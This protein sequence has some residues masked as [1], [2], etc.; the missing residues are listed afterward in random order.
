MPIAVATLAITWTRVPETRAPGETRLDL[1]GATLAT[2]GLGGVVFGLL[3]APRL[4]FTHP[5]IIAALGGGTAA[6]GTFLWVEQHTARPMLPLDVFRSRTFSGA[7]L[8]TLLLYAALSGILFFLPF[9][10][11]QVHGYTP[12]EAG[13]ALLPLIALL[14]LLS[15]WAGRLIDRYGPRPPLVAGP[16]VAGLGFVLLA[17]PGTSGAYWTTFFP[18]IMVLGLGMAITVAPLTTT[19]MGAA[20]AERAG[21]ASGINNAVSRTASL[22][23]I[24]V[25]G[26]VAYQRFGSTLS[27]RMERLGIPPAAR[28]ILEEQRGK[29][30]A[31]VIPDSLPAEVQGSLRSTVAAA[32]VDAFRSLSLLGAGLA[33]AAALTAWLMVGR[34][35]G[36]KNEGTR[37]QPR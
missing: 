10:L 17:L 3:E 2:V 27:E 32:F 11:I 24:A 37:K 5:G 7:N 13:G 36:R 1:L 18:P 21:L 23:A 4:G 29:L 30:A 34:D 8:L 19:V 31:A 12:A 15:N 26:I 9:N 6:L 28:R 33:V 35:A 14:S 20:G 25:F 16:L 22:L